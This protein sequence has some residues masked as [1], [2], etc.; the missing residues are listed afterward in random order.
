MSTPE[1]KVQRDDLCRSVSFVTRD[2]S[3][4]NDGFTLDGYGAVFNSPTRIDS[5][6]GCFDELIAPGAF[7]KS[8]RE[9]TPRMQFDHGSHPLIGSIPIGRFETIEEDAKGLHVIG[10]LTDNWLIQPVRDAI[11]EGGIDGMS[12][13]FSVVKEEWRDGEGKLVKN[14]EELWDLM[15]EGMRSGE[16]QLTRT[17]KEV[18]MT[19]VGP[20]VWPAY[21]NTEVGVRSRKI[22]I[23]L[24]DRASLARATFLVDQAVRETQV[25]AERK[26]VGVNE[27]EIDRSSVSTEEVVIGNVTTGKLSGT[28]DSFRIESN[29]IVGN[30]ITGNLAEIAE[31]PATEERA[32]SDSEEPTPTQTSD[33]DGHSETHSPAHRARVMREKR[34]ELREYLQS[35]TA[36][37]E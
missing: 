19:E 5:W 35:I 8:L 36:R 6:E 18:R 22:T 25:E 34:M 3:E 37:K 13:R 21:D 31:P 16:A 14:D 24:G 20:V 15:L 7:K 28:A 27:E 29:K 4:P 1:H 2:E 9:R 12:F 30:W 26:A 17:L 23:D 33:A 11:A 10:R 32:E